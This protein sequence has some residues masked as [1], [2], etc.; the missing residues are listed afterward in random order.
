MPTE[1]KSKPANY[2]NMLF[3]SR[4]EAKWAIFFDYLGI[5]WQYGEFWGQYT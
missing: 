4:L 5:R 3:K 1:I 2:K